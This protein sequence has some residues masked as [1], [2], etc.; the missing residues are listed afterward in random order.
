MFRIVR[1][2]DFEGEHYDLYLTKDNEFGGKGE[3]LEFES[4][5]DAELMR[6]FQEDNSPYN[7][8]GDYTFTVEKD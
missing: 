1:S 5:H 2:D 4:L 6:Q 3:A 7:H 8:T